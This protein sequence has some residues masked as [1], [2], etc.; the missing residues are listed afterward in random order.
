MDVPEALIEEECCR[1][2]TRILK[3]NPVSDR[4]RGKG[5]G[6]LERTGQG[7]VTCECRRV[8]VDLYDASSCP[9][10]KRS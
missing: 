6:E 9:A 5:F 7:C 3:A 10:H 8:D 4:G 1:P 2:F